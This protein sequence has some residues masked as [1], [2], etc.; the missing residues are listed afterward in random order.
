LFSELKSRN[1]KLA[2]DKDRLKDELKRVHKTNRKLVDDL[3]T[4]ET[5]KKMMHG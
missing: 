2:G 5:S 4:V 3:K 1:E